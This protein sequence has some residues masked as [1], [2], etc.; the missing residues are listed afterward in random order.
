MIKRAGFA[1]AFIT[2]YDFVIEV[3]ITSIL[4][5]KYDLDLL[6]DLFPLRALGNLIP[7]PFGKYI[8]RQTQTTVELDDF[9]I[10]AIYAGL[11]LFLSFRMIQKRDLR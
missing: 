2:F 1:I 6:A 7:L 9:V 11:F 5:L 8:M 4:D 3:V 10:Y